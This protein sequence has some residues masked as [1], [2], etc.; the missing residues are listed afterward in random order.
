IILHVDGSEATRTIPAGDGPEHFYTSTILVGASGSKIQ[1]KPG[2]TSGPP[3]FNGCF[4]KVELTSSGLHLDLTRL[5][6]ADLGL[7]MGNG[8]IEYHCPGTVANPSSTENRGPGSNLPG[9]DSTNPL[10]ISTA[11]KKS[12][13]DQPITFLTPESFIIVPSWTPTSTGDSNGGR[14]KRKSVVTGWSE[15][16]RS[17]IS[18]QFRTTEESGVLL[19]SSPATMSHNE[20]AFFFVIELR[21][22]HLELRVG[23]GGSRRRASLQLPNG[24]RA[25]DGQW[26]KLTLS[27][28]RTGYVIFREDHGSS[29]AGGSAST[30]AGGAVREFRL[31]GSPGSL[32]ETGGPLFI[33]GISDLGKNSYPSGLWSEPG[34]HRGFVGCLR[35]LSVGGVKVDFKANLAAPGVQS[36]CGRAGA[37]KCPASPCFHGAVCNEGWNRPICDCSRTHF[38]GPTCETP[39]LSLHFTGSEHVTAALSEHQAS[40]GEEIL[41]RFRTEMSTCIL[42]ASQ[43]GGL[44]QGSLQ[45]G[46]FRLVYRF[47]ATSANQ[48]N[49]SQVVTVTGY[50]LDDS[51]WHYIRI[52]RTAS[53]VA[54]MVDQESTFAETPTNVRVRIGSLRFGRQML[55]FDGVTANTG[56]EGSLSFIGE[57]QHLRVNGVPL[58][59]S[60]AAGEISGFSIE[61]NI[62][63]PGFAQSSGSLLLSSDHFSTFSSPKGFVALSASPFRGLE[64]TLRIRPMVDSGLLLHW[65]GA[66]GSGLTLELENARLKMIVTQPAVTSAATAGSADRHRRIE[67][68]PNS[69]SL[70]SASDAHGSASRNHK[71]S[72]SVL[73]ASSYQSSSYTS[74]DSSSVSRRSHVIHDRVALDDNAMH[75]VRVHA[76]TGFLRLRVDDQETGAIEIIDSGLL[77]GLVYIGGVRDYSVL[78]STVSSRSGFAGCVGVEDVNGQ[79]IKLAEEAVI[80][81][82]VVSQGC[83]GEEL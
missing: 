10:G 68:G 44:V 58:S 26:H 72:G 51:A 74:G 41:F 50:G 16:A 29:S 1:Q 13:K 79:S 5:A 81:S 39:A 71:Y 24:G 40:F 65:P 69:I 9:A 45:D 64:I 35:D 18:L 14:K 38:A 53:N 63:P 11:T 42:F 20:R 12:H 4:K 28:D 61:S 59:E 8:E 54:V 62:L 70:N 82:D 48:R 52:L 17:E 33:G 60:L 21:Q 55:R 56:G 2:V 77:Q 37:P 25:S 78:P 75:S 67:N 36:G 43:P 15:D 30:A 19:Y 66:N 80:P 7:V 34:L 6:K 76:A 49:G 3:F 47:S 73:S 83:A 57:I 32:Y 22:G 46:K 23:V 27:M 31:H